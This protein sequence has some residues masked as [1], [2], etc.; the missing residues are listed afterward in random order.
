MKA[1]IGECFTQFL[2]HTFN[3]MEDQMVLLLSPQ[4]SPGP[5]DRQETWSDC[6]G[7]PSWKC[8]VK[9]TRKSISDTPPPPPPLV[10]NI[11]V[12]NYQTEGI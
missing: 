6:L 10:G 9:T 11:A 3:M 2:G 8:E 12:R 1:S 7:E 5:E 4:S